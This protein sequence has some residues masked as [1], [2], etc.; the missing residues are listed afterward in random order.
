VKKLIF[1]VDY[2]V[3]N[4][5]KTA[6]K[7]KVRTEYYENLGAMVAGII[8]HHKDVKVLDVLEFVEKYIDI[9]ICESRANMSNT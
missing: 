9:T 8:Q 6:G 7:E 1:I 3:D 2:Y 5:E 4:R